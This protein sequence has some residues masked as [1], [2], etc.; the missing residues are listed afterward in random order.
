MVLRAIIERYFDVF[1]AREIRIC[2]G[3]KFSIDGKNQSYCKQPQYG[4]H[5]AESSSR[6]VEK[7]VG[8]ENIIEADEGPW[9]SGRIGV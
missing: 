6:L 5:E 2:R 3:Y 8:E 9:G 7:F 4:P 1:L